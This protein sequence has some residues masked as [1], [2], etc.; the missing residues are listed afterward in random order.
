[1]DDHEVAHTD[2]NSLARLMDLGRR[3]DA[4]WSPQELGAI[5]RH[6]LAAPLEFDLGAEGDAALADRIADYAGIQPPI[7]TFGELLFHPHPPIELLELVKEYAKSC[8]AGDDGVLPDEIATVLYALGIAA[9]MTKCDRRITRLD[10]QALEHL[11]DWVSEQTWLD[12][13]SRQLLDSA[14]EISAA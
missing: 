13:A 7:R 10:D 14:R 3:K 1:M 6:Q 2:D 8:R 9:A 12:A 5:L 11:I 4:L